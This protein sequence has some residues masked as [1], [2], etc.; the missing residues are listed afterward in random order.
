LEGLPLTNYVA[1]GLDEAVEAFVFGDLVEG[2]LFE[3]GEVVQGVDEGAADDAGDAAALGLGDFFQMAFEGLIGIK[4][5]GGGI[6]SCLLLE[7]KCLFA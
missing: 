5:N 1:G 2:G 3:G 6:A 7:V 4:G